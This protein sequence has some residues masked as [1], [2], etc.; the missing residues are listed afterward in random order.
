MGA[1]VQLVGPPVWLSTS[2]TVRP[3]YDITLT[4]LP[5]GWKDYVERLPDSRIPIK[6]YVLRPAVGRPHSYLA[7][8]KRRGLALAVAAGQ[9]QQ[10]KEEVEDEGGTVCTPPK[11]QEDMH[12]EE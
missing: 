1:E 5:E 7:V 12:A 10:Q 4:G 11:T 8:G 3:V 9:A 6:R 2:G